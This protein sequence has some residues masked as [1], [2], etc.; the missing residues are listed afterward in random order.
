M[1]EEKHVC[2][3]CGAQAN[4]Q[5]KNG[6]WCCSVKMNYCPEIKRIRKQKTLQQWNNL[7]EKGIKNL[8]D[9]PEEQRKTNKDK[10]QKGICYYCGRQ[11]HYQ[12]KNGKWC[13]HQFFSQCPENKNKNSLGVLKAYENGLQSRK[14]F[15]EQS[16]FRQ[17]SGR[18]GKN[19]FNSKQVKEW[20]KRL[21]KK[22]LTKDIIASQLGHIHNDQEIQ[23]IIGGMYSEK[24]K[25]NR[26][27]SNGYK[28][29]WYKGYWC[30]SSWQ[31]AFVI[32]NLQHNIKF[33]RNLQ[34]FKYQFKG[35]THTFFPDFKMEDGSYVQ[36]K[37]WFGQKNQAKIASF[38]NIILISKKQI[39]PYLEY[40]ILK[41]GKDF[42][43][44]YE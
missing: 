42:Y 39:E 17:G 27:K 31:L 34:K 30:D 29:G 25:S 10:G 36:I 18:R 15:T 26:N 41:Y 11:A 16:R 37:G 5:F 24:R 33:K 13:C 35:R 1:E 9:T 40:V 43:N 38:P 3:Y 19:K 21:S 22:Y 4:Y 28:K 8:K 44:L 32:Y 14:V 23:K 20:G 6:K 2:C 7:K 12:L